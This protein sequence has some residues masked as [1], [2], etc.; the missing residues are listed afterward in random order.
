MKGASARDRS[1][2]ATRPDVDA[3]FASE[4]GLIVL[5]GPL[6][7]GKSETGWRLMELLAPAA[8]VDID[9]TI[10]VRPFDW[11]RAPD[12]SYAF[13]SAA[14]LARHHHEAGYRKIVV[15][16][17]FETFE[18]LERL[19]SDFDGIGPM[20]VFRLTCSEEELQERIRRRGHPEFEREIM[21]GTELHAL[22][23]S[24]AAREDLG[25]A[26]ETTGRSVEQVAHLILDAISHH[27]APP[28]TG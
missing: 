16:W 28:P 8:M 9:H 14:L 17:V 7:V 11:R 19:R 22:L 23:E 3:G 26:V 5:N 20:R 15:S 2:A 4:S 18:Q 13:A 24:T 27:A 21:R 1:I 6:G 12:Q 10:A 25:I